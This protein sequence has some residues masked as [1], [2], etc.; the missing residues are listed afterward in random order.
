M[1]AV[2]RLLVLLALS[3]TEQAPPLTVEEFLG[4]AVFREVAVSP[5]GR[6]VALVVAAD[7]F[8]HDRMDVAVWRVEIGAEGRAAPPV[9]WTPPGME[10]FFARWSPDGRRLAFLAIGPSPGPPQLFVAEVGGEPRPLTEPGRFGRGVNAADWTPDGEALVAAAPAAGP[11][12]PWGDALR[13]PAPAPRTAFY[14]LPVAGSGPPPQPFATVADHAR[15][16]VVSPD[17]ASVGFLTGPTL[18]PTE[19]YDSFS[20]DEL[21]LL[22]GEGPARQVTRNLAIEG[23]IEWAR[24]GNGWV[25]GGLGEPGAERSLWTAGRLFRVA[26]DGR[27]ETLA[28]GFAGSFGDFFQMPDGALVA[29]AQVSTGSG[30]YRIDP[31]FSGQAG[32]ARELAAFRGLVSR[33][34]ASRDGSR[35]AFVLSD[36]RRFPE[37]Y[38]ANGLARLASAQPATA[39]N[40]APG[41][42]PMPEVETVSWPSDGE[43]IEGVLR[44]P[45]GRRGDRRLPLV[46]SLHGGPWQAASEAAVGEFPESSYPQ[47]LAAQGYLVLEPNYLGSLGRGDAFARA[48][49]GFSCSRPVADVLAGVDFLTGRGWADPARV[50]VVGHSFGAT[51]ANCLIARSG[52]FRA[53]CSSAGIWNELSYFGTADTF[54]LSDVRFLGKAPWEAFAE[55][56]RESAMSGAGDVRTPTL[57]TIGEADRRTPVSQAWEMY[58][59][60]QRRGVE[61][62]LL[63]FPGEAHYLLR[64]SHRKAKLQAELAWLDRHLT[65]SGE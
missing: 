42:K 31:N 54:V 30:L 45:P 48:I 29:A 16:V 1:R 24:R 33:L 61:A 43:T 49:E 20:R 11:E 13:L 14:R 59:A 2:G 58:R 3:L 52:R 18:E 23:R 39:F 63:V 41:R 15:D 40:A 36:G 51:L 8:A 6:F 5:D 9:R 17:G 10:P 47:L 4:A 50:A 60:L 34:S 55:Y 46:V 28:P 64:P 35:I 56:W 32:Q 12:S 53:A 19:L 22:P 38:L 44:W 27:V 25:A 57:I 37:L 26:A 7:D 21:F 65:I 62:E